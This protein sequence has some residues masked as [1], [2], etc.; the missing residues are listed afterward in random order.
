ML[1]KIKPWV[2]VFFNNVAVAAAHALEIYKLQRIAI[3][4]FDVH[5]GNGTENIF[6]NDPRVLYCSSFESP[7]YP[8]SGVDTKSD[9][10]LNVPLT[11]G[12]MG[13][14]FREKVAAKWFEAIAR[15]NPEIVFF[16]AGFDAFMDD[17]MS[18][19]LLAE[20]DYAWITHEIKNM[21]RDTCQGRMISMLEG[22]YDLNSLGH[23]VCAH[24]QAMIN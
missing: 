14:I 21:T 6:Q 12:T 22:G 7:F 13:K 19:L 23:C 17:E 11:A 8:Y 3:V 15:F 16:S 1:K 9:H 18:N 24:L 4:D 10:I 20:E 5:H 2:F